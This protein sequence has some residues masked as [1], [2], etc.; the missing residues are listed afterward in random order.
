MDRTVIGLSGVAGAGKD[1]FFKLL[2]KKMTV[3]RFALADALKREASMWTYKQ[4]GIDALNCSR[5]EKETIRP[6][7]VQH[8]TQKRKMSKGRYWID[9]LDRDIKGFLLNAVTEDVPVIT[10]IRYQEY[11]GDEVDW[12]TKELD[13][14]LVHISQFEVKRSV[15]CKTFKTPA[16]EEEAKM[17]PI[18]KELADYRISWPKVDDEAI[19]EEV[20]NQYVNRFINFYEKCI[21]NID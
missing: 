9:I 13:G 15:G 20:L 12:V 6:F 4:Y 5:E 8:G 19:R 14:L 21:G 7:L 2:S 10:D 11:E 3:R 18:I 17:D 1:L 16:N